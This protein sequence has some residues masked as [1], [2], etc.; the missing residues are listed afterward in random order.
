MKDIHRS[1]RL[2]ALIGKMVRIYFTDGSRGEGILGYSDRVDITQG[3]QAGEYFIR[4]PSGNTVFRKSHVKK[5]LQPGGS[6][7]EG[8]QRR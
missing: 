2:D 4:K 1:A 5:I 6:K 7:R 3:L 8:R